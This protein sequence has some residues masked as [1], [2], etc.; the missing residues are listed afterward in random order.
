MR[1]SGEFGDYKYNYYKLLNDGASSAASDALLV[2]APTCDTWQQGDAAYALI[3]GVKHEVELK[4]LCSWST[5]ISDVHRNCD[6]KMENRLCQM[7]LRRANA[8]PLVG[9]AY[10]ERCYGTVG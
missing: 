1:A 7:R 8:P 4:P 2:E 6:S 5:V 3:D 10:N 9:L